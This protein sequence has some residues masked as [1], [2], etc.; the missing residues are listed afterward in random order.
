MEASQTALG[1]SDGDPV[2]AN[3]LLAITQQ[4]ETAGLTYCRVRLEHNVGGSAVELSS[5][6]GTACSVGGPAAKLPVGTLPH[7]YVRLTVVV[8]LTEVM[9]DNIGCFCYSPA[10]ADKS[11]FATTILRYEL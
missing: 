2:P 4:L 5:T 3:V 10:S 7:E 9:P 1:G 11:A 8:N 6:N